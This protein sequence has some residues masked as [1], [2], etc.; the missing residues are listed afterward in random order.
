V[1]VVTPETVV[2]FTPSVEECQVIDL[3]GVGYPEKVTADVRTEPGT[4][5]A[6]LAEGA[7]EEVT[8]GPDGVITF[9]SVN[10]SPA[11]VLSVSPPY[12]MM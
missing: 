7:A 8:V 4:T 2:Q 6:G 3:V 5:A 12:S 10:A 1:L 11:I 9:T